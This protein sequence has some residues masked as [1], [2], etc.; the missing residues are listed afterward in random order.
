MQIKPGRKQHL[1]GLGIGVLPRE[2]GLAVF[3]PLGK[4]V[5]KL[6]PLGYLVRSNEG[7]DDGAG[8]RAG[9]ENGESEIKSYSVV[10]SNFKKHVGRVVSLE[11]KRVCSL[12]PTFQQRL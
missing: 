11:T 10:V 5:P 2:L 12:F 1:E 9:P 8:H 7:F 6:V 4:P 3:A